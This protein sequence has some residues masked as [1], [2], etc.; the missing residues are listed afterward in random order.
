[1]TKLLLAA[2]MLLL[3]AC[4]IVLIFSI[5]DLLNVYNTLPICITCH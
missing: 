3:S 2:S 1:M 4:M 5:Y